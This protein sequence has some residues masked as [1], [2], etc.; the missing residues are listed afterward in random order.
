[1]D[2]E[3]RYAWNR[4]PSVALWNL[5]RLGGSLHALVPDVE[6]LRGVL[7]GYE[8]MFTRAFHQR[9]AAKLGLHA[10]RPDDEPLLDDLLRLMHEQRADFTLTFRRLADA[11]RGQPQGFQDLFID[12]AAAQAW[13]ERL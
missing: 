11:V 3:G 9:M 8:G 12:R 2:S 10:W 7:D 5:Y 4:Q 6:A 1:S 13:Y